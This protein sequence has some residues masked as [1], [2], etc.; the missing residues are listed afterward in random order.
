MQICSKEQAGVIK[1][2]REEDGVA[3]RGSRIRKALILGRSNANTRD[4]GSGTEELVKGSTGL[5]RQWQIL[6]GLKAILSNCTS[7]KEKQ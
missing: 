5:N 2:D 1:T 6:R 3:G 7:S 4:E